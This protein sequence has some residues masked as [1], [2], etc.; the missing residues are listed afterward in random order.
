MVHPFRDN[1]AER[2]H[3]ISPVAHGTSAVADQGPCRRTG[4]QRRANGVG[5]GNGEALHDESRVGGLNE[6]A[7]DVRPGL[8]HV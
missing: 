2:P 5:H 3:Q 7:P 1:A 8:L 6:I 4:P